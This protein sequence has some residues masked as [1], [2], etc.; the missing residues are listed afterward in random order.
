M[1]YVISDGIGNQAKWFERGLTLDEAKERV[2][3][4][5]DATCIIELKDAQTRPS[6]VVPTG[7]VWGVAE[8]EGEK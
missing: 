2:A 3:D 4:Y 8:P 7:R 1:E 6:G 5:P